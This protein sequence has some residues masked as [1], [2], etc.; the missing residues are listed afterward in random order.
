MT[1]VNKIITVS[2]F[3]HIKFCVKIGKSASEMLELL[4]LAYSEYTMKKLRFFNGKGDSRK[5]EKMCKLNQEVGSEKC[6]SGQ[7]TNLDA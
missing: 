3:R 7:C 1:T 6:K 4:T 2:A 5:G